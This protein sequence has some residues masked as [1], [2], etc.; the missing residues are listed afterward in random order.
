MKKLYVFMLLLSLA[1]VSEA[2][3]NGYKSLILSHKDGQETVVSLE[4][5]MVVKVLDGKVTMT[6]AKGSVEALT[7]DLNNW[8]YYTTA[9]PDDQNGW[10]GL[11]MPSADAVCVSIDGDYIVIRNVDHGT[12]VSLV[13]VDGKI[14]LSL[15]TADSYCKIPVADIRGGFYVLTIKDKSFKIAVK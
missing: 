15:R 9:A 8:R 12:P 4:N 7:S 14:V 3:I 10:Q 1:T 5:D 2:T 11:D 6:S 13:S